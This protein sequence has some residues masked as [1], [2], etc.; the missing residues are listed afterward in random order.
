MRAPSRPTRSPSAASR[1]SHDVTVGIPT[2]RQYSSSPPTPARAIRAGGSSCLD[3]G[4][5]IGHVSLT[6]AI[7]SA[8]N[9]PPGSS[10]TQSWR[11]STRTTLLA[12]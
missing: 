6:T 4:R 5:G 9:E 1:R 11:S 8:A 12:R 10:H 2:G 7:A 3:R